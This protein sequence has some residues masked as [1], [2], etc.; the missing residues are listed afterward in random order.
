MVIVAPT[1]LVA[2]DGRNTYFP[3]GYLLAAFVTKALYYILDVDVRLLSD[4]I[5]LIQGVTGPSSMSVSP[6]TATSFFEQELLGSNP[7]P[8]I[9]AQDGAFAGTWG[10]DVRNP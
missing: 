10:C 4:P 2:V 3:K 9:Q 6:P 5:P 7:E 1:G 8:A